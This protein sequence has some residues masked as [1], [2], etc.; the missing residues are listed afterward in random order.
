MM[1]NQKGFTVIELLIAVALLLVALGLGYQLLF[2]AQDNFE[3]S[4]YQ[5]ER[6]NE[7]IA[8]SSYMADVVDKSIYIR[9][10][11]NINDIE[12]EDGAIYR[13][14]D[15]EDIYLQNGLVET[16]V[17]ANDLEI[18]FAKVLDVNSDYYNDLLEITVTA[19]DVNYALSTKVKIENLTEDRR[20]VGD[21]QASILIFR[22]EETVAEVPIS[23][24]NCYIATAAN[25]SNMKPSVLLLRRF[26]DQV[27]LKSDIG[28]NVVGL[29][30]KFSPPLAKIISTNPIYRFLTRLI[31]LPVVGAVMIVMQP[32]LIYS[33]IIGV[34]FAIIIYTKKKYIIKNI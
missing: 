34:I 24:D 28:T 18:S 4:E 9:I 19:S 22:T 27:L 3:R 7:V 29:Y 12:N 8:L 31:L 17:I 25:G 20:I 1:K 11:T 16:V 33:I 14:I 10:T 26:R 13:E 32:I 21:D 5:W 15:G 6:Q 2:Y 23:I 30:Y